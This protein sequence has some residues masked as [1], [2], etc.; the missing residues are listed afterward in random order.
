M[1]AFDRTMVDARE[2]EPV[3]KFQF[4]YSSTATRKGV[5]DTVGSRQASPDIGSLEDALQVFGKM[6]PFP[7]HWGQCSSGAPD[8]FNILHGVAVSA[9]S[10]SHVS[11]GK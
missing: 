1:S 4:S 9:K 3:C 6:G 7:T 8:V 11:P 10:P 2:S 5:H